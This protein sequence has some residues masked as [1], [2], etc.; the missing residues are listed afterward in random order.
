MNGMMQKPDLTSVAGATAPSAFGFAEY[1]LSRPDA[2]SAMGS[3][4]GLT[5]LAQVGLSPAIPGHW[6][7]VS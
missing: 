5:I 6:L 3:A 1:P 7:G 4:S 2:L